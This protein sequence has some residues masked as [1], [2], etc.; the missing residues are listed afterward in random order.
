MTENDIKFREKA[1][2]IYNASKSVVL[3]IGEKAWEGTGE[4]LTS[5]IDTTEKI[6]QG[7][8]SGAKK[9]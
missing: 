6:Y 2:K 4:F 5:P 7:L 3:K 8:K 9:P 1:N